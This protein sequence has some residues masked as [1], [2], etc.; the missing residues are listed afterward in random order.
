MLLSVTDPNGRA[1]PKKDGGERR[2]GIPS[3]SDRVAQTVAK[4]SFEPLVEPYFLGDSYGYRP[5]KSDH[6]ALAVTRERCWRYDWVLEF[7][8]RVCSTTLI[9]IC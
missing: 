6:Q 9:I 4:L 2:L 5:G 1:I 7:D 8:I 3:V